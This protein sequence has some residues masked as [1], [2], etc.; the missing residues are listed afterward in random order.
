[1][2]ESWEV[3]WGEKQLK[4]P[5]RGARSSLRMRPSAYDYDL[6]CDDCDKWMNAARRQYLRNNWADRS[7]CADCESAARPI[8]LADLSRGDRRSVDLRLI[9]RELTE[10]VRKMGKPETTE[11]ERT[12]LGYALTDLEARHAALLESEG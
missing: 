4:R 5:K 7:V 3:K 6:L 2:S 9:E 12:N 10:V 11:A 1:M 8:Y